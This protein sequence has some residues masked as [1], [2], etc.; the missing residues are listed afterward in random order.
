VIKPGF[1]LFNT[2]VKL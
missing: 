2:L 1:I